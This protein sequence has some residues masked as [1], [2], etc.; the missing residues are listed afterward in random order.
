MSLL[1]FVVCSTSSAYAHPPREITVSFDAETSTVHAV[2]VHRVSNPA[3]HYIEKVDIGINGEEIAEL[4]FEEQETSREQTISYEL[5][6]VTSGD[7]ISVEG[8]CNLSGK[9][10]EELTVE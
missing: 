5:P 7:T 2:I 6:H 3:S 9:R 1:F 4:T 8:Y 10:E